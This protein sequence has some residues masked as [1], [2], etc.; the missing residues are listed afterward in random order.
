MKAANDNMPSTKTKIYHYTAPFFVDQIIASKFIELELHNDF[1]NLVKAANDNIRNAK[2]HLN[3]YKS[4]GRYVWFTEAQSAPTA[5]PF[6]TVRFSFFA[7]DI[8]AEK[9]ETVRKRQIFKMG[10]R[11][12]DVISALEETAIEDGDDPKNWWVSCKRVPVTPDHFD[13][14]YR[15]PDPSYSRDECFTFSD[16]IRSWRRD[17]R[18]NR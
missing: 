8:G 6:S 10:G 17:E 1:A 2:I 14:S 9:W 11:A 15:L 16:L 18:Y 4:S 3:N 13:T 5:G 7:E 12:F